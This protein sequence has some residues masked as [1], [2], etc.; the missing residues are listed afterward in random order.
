MGSIC[1]RGIDNE[2]KQQLKEQAAQA[3]ISVNALLLKYIHRGVGI[4]SGD[5]KIHHDL[6]SLAGT[7]TDKQ[8]QEFLQ[9][10]SQF[11]K[12]DEEMWK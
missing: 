6:D 1:L 11:E 2:V 7:W 12:I 9:S 8:L 3:G 10:T 5:R 4:P